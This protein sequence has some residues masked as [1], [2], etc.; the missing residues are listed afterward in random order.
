MG[1]QEYT[2][3]ARFPEP[4]IKT[5]V[6][7]VCSGSAKV[8]CGWTWRVK[9]DGFQRLMTF[10]AGLGRREA[11]DSMAARQAGSAGAL[12]YLVATKARTITQRKL[13]GL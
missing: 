13:R 8:Q 5:M 11:Q 4:N 7:G 6:P 1:D 2:K 3:S 9:T 12:R 10:G